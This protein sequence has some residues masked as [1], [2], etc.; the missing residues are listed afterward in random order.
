MTDEEYVK[1]LNPFIRQ[2]LAEAQN[3]RQRAQD[4]QE[5]ADQNRRFFRTTMLQL[6]ALGLGVR[7]LGRQ[8]GLSHAQVA[9]LTSAAREDE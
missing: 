6:R 8:V 7:F 4:F 9:R 2:R 5:L 3:A 1:Q